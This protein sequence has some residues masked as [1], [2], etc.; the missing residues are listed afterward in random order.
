MTQRLKW[1]ALLQDANRRGLT[2][3]ELG[4]ELGR[5]PS[6]VLRAAERHG[7][8]L[9]AADLPP[10]GQC[11]FPGCRAPRFSRPCRWCRS[12]RRQERKGEEL[13]PILRRGTPN[14]LVPFGDDAFEIILTSRRGV[15][16]DRALIDKVD[17]GLVTGGRLCR[18]GSG[19]GYAY[20]RDRDRKVQYLH[21]LVADAMG[22]D[23][24]LEVDMVNGDGLDCR[25]G[26]IRAATHQQNAE[27]VPVHA[28]T[29]SGARGVYPLTGRPG[30]YASVTANGVRHNGERRDTIAQATADAVSLRAT[31]MSHH[32]EDR[33]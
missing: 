29:L 12:H 11:R 18:T 10:L 33:C 24:A 16:V 15:E 23:P 14:E 6:S 8:E 28:R 31:Y 19:G 2:A 7:I 27:N 5:K 20:R 26:N 13:Y 21:R 4:A 9:A 30:W 3:V 32:N 25:R 22:L 1:G 17:A